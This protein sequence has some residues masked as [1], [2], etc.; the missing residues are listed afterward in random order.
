[1]PFAVAFIVAMI[2]APGLIDTLKRRRVGQTISEDG[3]E[4]HKP[5]A[6]T[7]TM[8]GLIILAGILAAVLVLVYIYMKSGAQA[9]D[10]YV[11]A[12]LLL[13]VGFAALGLADDYLTIH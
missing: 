3:P 7:P 10:V 5:K 11:A 13:V 1:M 2:F 8:G 9:W 6:G 12:I 4:S